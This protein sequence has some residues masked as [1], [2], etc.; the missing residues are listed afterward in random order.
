M[1]DPRADQASDSIARQADQV[2]AKDKLV[3]AAEAEEMRRGFA[4]ES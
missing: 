2:L 4:A 1:G 3:G